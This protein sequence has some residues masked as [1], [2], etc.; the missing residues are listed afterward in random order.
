M[1]NSNFQIGQEL[2]VKNAN[3]IIK[4][5]DVTAEKFPNIKKNHPHIDLQFD[6]LVCLYYV[7]DNEAPT[8]LYKQTRHD[9]NPEDMSSTEFEP[10]V[11]CEPKKGRAL[12][13]DGKYYHSSSSP[14]QSSRC[15]INFDVLGN[16][17]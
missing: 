15:I 4:Q 6:H 2:T 3:Y 8:T 10:L 11:T 17:K 7:N 12:F 14:N 16:V 5:I 13:F 1:K 9:V